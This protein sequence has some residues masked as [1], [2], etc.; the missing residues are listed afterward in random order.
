M[1]AGLTATGIVIT[2]TIGNSLTVEFFSVYL[3]AMGI[4]EGWAKFVGAKYMN[5]TQ[6]DK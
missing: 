3:A 5:T 6:S 1:L 2:F 4:S